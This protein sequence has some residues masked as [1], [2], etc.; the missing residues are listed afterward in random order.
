[1]D[2]L[3]P[4]LLFSLLIIV[5]ALTLIAKSTKSSRKSS[6]TDIFVAPLPPG[7]RQLPIIGQLHHLLSGDPLPHISLRNLSSLHGSIILLRLGRVNLA[8]VSSREAAEEILRTQDLCFASRPQLTRNRTMSYGYNDIA[9][10]PYG[11]N[12]RLLRKI[13]MT[14]LLTAKRVASFAAIRK[15]AVSALVESIAAAAGRKEAVNLKQ[16]LEET[17]NDII[18]KAAFSR[19]CRQGRKAELLSMM[20]DM[21]SLTSGLNVVEFFPWLWFVD[22]MLGVKGQI[23]RLFKRIDEILEELIGEH[24]DRLRLKKMEGIESGDEDLLDVLLRARDQGHVDQSISTENVKAIATDILFAGT[25]TS[26]T[27]MQWAMSELMRNPK[28]MEKM[29]KEIRQVAAM[30]RKRQIEEE[31]L[32]QLDYLKQVIKETLRLHPSLP[33]LLP[34]LCRETCQVQGYTVPA[35]TRVLVNAWALGRDSRY[36]K[37][38]ERFWPER[39]NEAL[40]DFKGANFEFLPF[41]AGRRIC[42]GINFGLASVEL[43]LA[44][45]LLCFDWE[46][47]DGLRAEDLDMSEVSGST[48]GRKVDLCLLA[49][50]YVSS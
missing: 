5:V 20:R 11:P 49:T 44:N 32:N 14:E 36:W 31:D 46:L 42:P 15:E 18:M 34:R 29:Q 45:L 35:G 16:K 1:M 10:A 33:L 38:P 6:S 2:Q 4:I 28:A 21:I 37:E 43:V 26:S 7:P 25:D 19:E 30:G 24:E 8:V 17:T 12:W 23:E 48:T 9:M 3:L 27:T 47:P 39:F 50:P 13:C 40:V 41:G 22:T